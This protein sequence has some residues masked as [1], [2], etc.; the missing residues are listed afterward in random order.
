MSVVQGTAF[1]RAHIH[2][3]QGYIPGIQPAEGLVKLNTNENPFPP[4]PRLLAALREIPLRVFQRYPDPLAAAFRNTAAR[5]HFVSPEQII[6]TNGGDELLRLALTT[7]VEPGSAIGVVTPCYGVYGVLAAI[8]QAPL[9]RVELTEKWSLPEDIAERWNA[10]GARLALLTNP[11][12]PSGGLFRIDEIARLARRFRG[13]LLL[14]EAY[15]DFVDPEFEH[16]A[17]TLL[18]RRSNLILLR[19]MSKGYALA[20]LRLAYGI[21]RPDVIAPMLEK[22]KDSYNVDAIAQRL[23]SIA[24]QDVAYAMK[25]WEH[26]R[27]ERVRVSDKLSRLGFNVAPSQ[28]NFVLASVPD[29]NHGYDAGKLY[30]ELAA[31]GVHVRWFNEDRLRTSLRVSIGTFEEN[32]CF[33]AAVEDI[34][35]RPEP[36]GQ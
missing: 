20:G 15:V 23:G 18:D 26:V 8:H 19:T 10:D 9:S 29:Q 33:L 35:S 4:S 36:N 3:M 24:L 14:D 12:A 25:S 28:S 2:A 7:F 16:D 17:T 30:H 27:I 1:E 11:H 31:V 22:T 6:A 34:L 32:N 13:V 5:R 21:G